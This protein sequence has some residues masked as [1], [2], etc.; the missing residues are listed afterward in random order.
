MNYTVLVNKKNKW[1]ESYL[2]K[3]NWVET[4]DVEGNT[5]LVEKETNQA[6]Q[7]LKR[8]LQEEKIEIGIRSG[9]RDIESQKEWIK[10]GSQEAKKQIAEPSFSEHHTGLALDIMIKEKD[11]CFTEKDLERVHPFLKECGFILR[12]PKGKEEITGYQYHPAHIRFVGKIPAKI[13]M[14][15][16]WTLEEYLEKFYAVLYVNK[17]QGMTSFDVVKKI[18][19][20]FGI[21]KVGHTGTLDPLATG[22][23][24]VA[25]GKATKIVE[26]LTAEDKE[27]IASAQLGI[28]TDTYD[29]T[30][31]V[32]EEK[33]VLKDYPLD[34]KKR[35][36]SS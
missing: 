15:K 22:V 27:Y 3:T 36:N 9:Y 28:Q 32:I 35:G 20:L 5:I 16:N 11:G 31:E 13:I 8:L 10:E 33:E 23:M 1:K 24:I 7:E 12:Y 21:K 6:F 4:K 34:K 25:V 17:P 18:S 2:K 26:L 30:G 19:N 29:I 14:E